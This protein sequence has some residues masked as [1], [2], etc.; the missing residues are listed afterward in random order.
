MRTGILEP[1]VALV[2]Q[3]LQEVVAGG[4][5]LP[6][7]CVSEDLAGEMWQ[8]GGNRGGRRAVPACKTPGARI[9]PR[10]LPFIPTSPPEPPLPRATHVSVCMHL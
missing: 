2:A 3:A 9:P 7:P 5:H 1:R 8:K 4:V 10:Y 6:V